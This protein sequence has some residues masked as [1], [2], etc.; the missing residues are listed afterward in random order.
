MKVKMF[1]NYTRNLNKMDQPINVIE[2]K[3]NDKLG[4]SKK[5]FAVAPDYLLN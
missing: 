4:H 5:Y 1:K 2:N 3:F